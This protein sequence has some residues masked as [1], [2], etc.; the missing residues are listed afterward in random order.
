[1]RVSGRVGALDQVLCPTAR[2]HSHSPSGPAILEPGE[3]LGLH[4]ARD[5]CCLNLHAHRWTDMHNAHAHMCQAPCCGLQPWGLGPCHHRALT[6]AV[7]SWGKL[8]CAPN[9]VKPYQAFRS[10]SNSF[11][12]A[13]SPGPASNLGR[14]HAEAPI[15][16]LSPLQRRGALRSLLA[17]TVS[18]R[19]H[20]LLS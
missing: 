19:R 16:R 15:Q 11:L 10:H 6:W 12:R 2:T 9:L 1:M 20:A 4:K 17:Q 14:P 7:P 18:T 5:I 8:L 13:A 3:A